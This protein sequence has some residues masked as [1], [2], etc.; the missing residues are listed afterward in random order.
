MSTHPR[1]T[2]LVAAPFTAFHADGSL[3]LALIEK[4][5]ASLVANG[6][7]GAF[8]CGT[9]GEGLSLTTAERMQV[10]ERWQQA[11]ASGGLRIIVH[12]GHTSLA[13]CRALAAHA[14][15][16][17]AA[18]IATL[19]PFF[20]KPTGVEEL[21]AFCAET[22]AAAPALPFYFYHIPSMTGVHFAA[23]DFL[24]AG[25]PR[26]PNL[27]GVKF[28][29]ENLLDFAECLRMDDQRFDVL[30]GRDEMLL[31]GL[32]LGGAGAIGSTYNFAAPVYHRIIAAFEKGDLATA[33]AEQARAN[34]MIS[35][36][37]RFGGQPAGKAMMKMIGLDCGPT[38]L[39]LRTL[40]EAQQAE[41]R[42]ALA[43]VGFFD[44]SSAAG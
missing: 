42:A 14:Q 21:V 9:T 29:F 41:L 13:D 40:S 3:N 18:G 37:L 39:P 44:F 33:Q 43:A 2:G 38:R 11:A 20:F 25:A 23:A 15:Q 10:A 24:R 1:L 22:A 30:F 12:V 4:Q 8:V 19:A 31:A 7:S 26:I 36:F 16:I 5:V 28:T 35:T 6:V 17:G 32:S 27:A 34:A